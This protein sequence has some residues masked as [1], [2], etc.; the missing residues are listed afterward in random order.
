MCMASSLSDRCREIVLGSLL[1]DGSL[2][3]HRP[4]VNARFSFRHSVTQSE[5]FW[6]KVKNLTEISSERCVWQ[7]EADGGFGGARLRYQSRALESL[8]ELYHQTHRGGRFVIRRE[9]LNQLTP[10]ALAIW[11]LDDG[12]LVG[13]SRKGV[14]CTDGFARRDIQMLAHYLSD[15]WYI[16]TVVGQVK[17]RGVA[18]YRL[19]LYSTEEL[20]KFLRLI[21]PYIP[22]SAMLLKALL[23]YRDQ[24]LQQR[25]I[26]EV[27]KR[28]SFSHQRVHEVLH[29]KRM[30][31]KTFRE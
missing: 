12:S 31:W 10:L 14:F 25:W 13:N 7:Q 28:T 30:K 11:W 24:K 19:W 23:L 27:C 6:W 5:Y 9:W 8:T 26:S 15:T 18:Y 4:Y 29:A 1:G 2:K 20:K 16:R 3:I 17:N 21:L 22:V